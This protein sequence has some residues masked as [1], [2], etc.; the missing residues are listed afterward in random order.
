M[1]ASPPEHLRSSE[2]KESSHA[3]LKLVYPD[4]A[5]VDVS[6]L[7][8]IIAILPSASLK[9]LVIK[10]KRAAGQALAPGAFHLEFQGQELGDP[11]T[12]LSDLGIR[13]GD[14]VI[15]RTA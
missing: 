2:T 6:A 7:P 9:V 4:L 14:E 15:V 5:P 11:D 1:R 10:L 13:T 12:K 3:D 8:Q